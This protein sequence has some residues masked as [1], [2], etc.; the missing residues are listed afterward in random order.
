MSVKY[1]SWMLNMRWLWNVVESTCFLFVYLTES[2]VVVVVYDR[3]TRAATDEKEF[4][5]V[6]H[7][8][9]H[10]NDLFN[11]CF[12]SLIVW[13]YVIWH[14]KEFEPFVMSCNWLRCEVR[15][16]VRVTFLQIVSEES[17]GIVLHL[18]MLVRN[19]IIKQKTPSFNADFH[20]STWYYVSLW[21]IRAPKLLRKP[22]ARVVCE[23]KTIRVLPCPHLNQNWQK[24]TK[25]NDFWL[26]QLKQWLLFCHE[27]NACLVAA[28][29]VPIHSLKF[30]SNHNN[31][32]TIKCQLAIVSIFLHSLHVYSKHFHEYSPLPRLSSC[33][34]PATSSHFI[35][36]RLYANSGY[37]LYEP[38]MIYSGPQ[39]LFTKTLY[40]AN[41]YPFKTSNNK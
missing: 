16:L 23:Y 29:I 22:I 4:R 13:R 37:S 6:I 21:K 39:S 18:P 19:S 30:N 41:R 20:L 3:I 32:S 24:K 5:W 9:A 14:F 10:R 25:N 11:W 36:F 2:G 31:S 26:W 38:T 34:Q 15:Y 40:R 1:L 8:T 35:M 12:L 28:K 7:K 27:I 33:R 17:K